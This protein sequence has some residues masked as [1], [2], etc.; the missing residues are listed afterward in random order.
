M[1]RRKS[2]RA[3]VVSLPVGAGSSVAHRPYPRRTPVLSITAGPTV[4]ALTLPEVISPEHVQF[5]RQ[6]ADQAAKYAVEVERKYR[7]LTPTAE[8][9]K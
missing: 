6:L 9:I 5:A 8:V 7:G 4:V 3:A 2:I 1:S